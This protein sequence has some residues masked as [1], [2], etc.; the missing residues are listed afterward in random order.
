M[1]N[2]EQQQSYHILYLPSVDIRSWIGKKVCKL[3]KNFR[4]LFEGFHL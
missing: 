3:G 4:H 2:K 1:Q